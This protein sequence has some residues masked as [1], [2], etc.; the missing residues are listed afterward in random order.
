MTRPARSVAEPPRP[1]FAWQRAKLL[2]RW[3]SDC[4]GVDPWV[5]EAWRREFRA[6]AAELVARGAR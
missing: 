1:Y 6:L 3:L 4:S 2:R 5:L